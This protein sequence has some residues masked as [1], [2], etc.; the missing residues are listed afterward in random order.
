M[1]IEDVNLLEAS[2]QLKQHDN[3]NPMLIPLSCCFQD[4]VPQWKP[5]CPQ[6]EMRQTGLYSWVRY[7]SPT[8]LS[9]LITSSR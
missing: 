5:T 7:K 3:S 6:M 8:D 1:K 9:K 2:I 4:P